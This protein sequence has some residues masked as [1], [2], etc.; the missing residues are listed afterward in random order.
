MTNRWPTATVRLGVLVVM[1]ATGCSGLLMGRAVAAACPNAATHGSGASASLPDCRAYEL[2]SPPSKNGADAMADTARTRAATDGGALEFSS[3]TGIDGSHGSGIAFEYMSVRDGKAG[4]N[5]WRTHG[6]TPLQEPLDLN[7]VIASGLEPRYVGEFSD[8]LD[9][10]VF[11]AKS[12]VTAGGQ[13]VEGL[14]NLYLRRDLRSTA[15]GSYDLVSDCPGCASPFAADKGVAPF[16]AG[17]SEDFG[18][19]L[20]ESRYQLTADAPGNCTNIG[21]FFSLFVCPPKLYE[22]DHGTVRL[23]GILPDGTSAPGAMAGRG[24]GAQLQANTLYTPGVISRDGSRVVFTAPPSFDGSGN[25]Y[26]RRNN[27]TTVQVNASER[28]DCSGD[29]ICGG[30]GVPDPAP[31]PA[32]PQAAMYSAATR[33][34]AQIFFTSGEQLTDDDQDGGTDLY[35]YDVE[36]AA[37]HHLTRLAGNVDGVVGVSSDGEYVYFEGGGV[38][39]VWHDGAIRQIAAGLTGGDQQAIIGSSTWLLD[40]DRL[41]GRVSPDGRQLLFAVAAPGLTGYDNSDPSGGVC[42]FSPQ[43]CVEVYVYDAAADGGQGKLTCVSCNTGMPAA[44]DAEF[45]ARVATG[46]ANTTSHLSHPLANDG[47]FVFFDTADALVAND[48]N[49]KRDVY[50]YDTTTGGSRLISNG[51]G[52]SDSIFMDASA[53]GND[54]F[55]LTREQLVGWDV[56]QNVDV[57][58]ARVDGGFSE[59]AGSASCSG[60]ACRAAPGSVPSPRMPGSAL[61]SD[62]S[63]RGSGRTSMVAVVRPT[64]HQLRRWASSGRVSL[65]VRVSGAGRV[66]VVAR[67]KRGTTAQTVASAFTNAGHAGTVVVRVVLSRT[68]RTYLARHGRLHLTLLVMYSRGTGLTRMGVTLVHVAAARLA[69]EGKR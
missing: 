27:A 22:W 53:N 58:D 8:T 1:A 36:A 63:D 34:G 10:G 40:A 64:R 65:R 37:G 55:F 3:L 19:V 26:T 11:L 5:G 29:P 45:N 56:D 2:V 61:F 15:V 69:Q 44:S 17:A 25:V 48:I 47:R 7:D 24:A 46:A 12:P 66:S 16:M 54:V 32:G 51:R 31:D 33:E 18:V 20:F 4:T 43:G 13:N 6:I 39:S 67:A 62:P 41:S 50:E 42:T 38:V 14:V 23:E 30:D 57:Y 9:A 59:P 28:T 49:G 52:T 35:R 60:D 68:A 21:S